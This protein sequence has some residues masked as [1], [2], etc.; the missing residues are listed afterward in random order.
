MGANHL[1]AIANFVVLVSNK[2]KLRLF[3]IIRLEHCLLIA[4]SMFLSGVAFGSMAVFK[5]GQGGSAAG[6]YH[7]S[8]GVNHELMADPRQQRDRQPKGRHARLEIEILTR[9]T[10]VKTSPNGNG[11][12]PKP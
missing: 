10:W 11:P 4:L 7:V 2:P 5:P 8:P 9:T 12:P 3:V 6:W 1:R